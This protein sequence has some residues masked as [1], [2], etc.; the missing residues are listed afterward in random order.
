ML[1][2]EDDLMKWLD[3][4]RPSYVEKWLKKNNV[5]YDYGK[6]GKI[7]TTLQA[8]NKVFDNPQAERIEF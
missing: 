3:Y 1:V 4:D 8:V 2:N 6:G 7:V 5:T